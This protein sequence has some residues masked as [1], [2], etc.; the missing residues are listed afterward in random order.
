M[1]P[2]VKCKNKHKLRSTTVW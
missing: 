2:A 1:T